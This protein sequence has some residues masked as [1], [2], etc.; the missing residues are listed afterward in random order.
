MYESLVRKNN[1][2]M[3]IQIRINE[4]TYE[5]LIIEAQIRAIASKTHTGKTKP[6]IGIVA[7]KIIEDYFSNK[8]DNSKPSR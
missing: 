4:K 1:Y 7:R 2:P 3:I 8:F 6:N 5:L